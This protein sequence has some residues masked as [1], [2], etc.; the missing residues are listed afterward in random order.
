MKESRVDLVRSMD[1]EEAS[2][3]PFSTPLTKLYQGVYLWYLWCMWMSNCPYT[4]TRGPMCCLYSKFWS[5]PR[6]QNYIPCI[7]G[8]TWWCPD[9]VFCWW[10]FQCFFSQNEVSSDIFWEMRSLYNGVHLCGIWFLPCSARLHMHGLKDHWG[11]GKYHHH[12][13]HRT[14]N[15]RNCN[16]HIV[17][18]GAEPSRR[19]KSI[20][21]P[22]PLPSRESLQSPGVFLLLE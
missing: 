12:Y 20:A 9:L 16:S 2:D 13:H 15:W 6:W 17:L 10:L 19:G 14:C 5:S 4:D 18:D 3:I 8:G 1:W 11:S 21:V 7:H 22:S